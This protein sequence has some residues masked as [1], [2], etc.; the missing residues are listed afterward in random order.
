[1]RSVFSWDDLSVVRHNK[2]FLL[3]TFRLLHVLFH[4]FPVLDFDIWVNAILKICGQRSK[5]VIGTLLGNVNHNFMRSGQILFDLSIWLHH[6]W[7]DSNRFSN[8]GDQVFLNGWI[9]ALVQLIGRIYHYC[10]ERCLWIFILIGI[11]LIQL[12]L[13]Q[14]SSGCVIMIFGN[15]SCQIFSFITLHGFW[16]IFINLSLNTDIRFWN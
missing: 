1:M 6:F 10:D 2:R 11:R 4:L 12:C 13:I 9:L 7:L 14:L 15:I 3:F 5:V 8:L 16:F